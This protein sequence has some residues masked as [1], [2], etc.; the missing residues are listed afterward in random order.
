MKPYP[1]IISHQQLAEAIGVGNSDH[2][3]SGTIVV[4]IPIWDGRI[5]EGVCCEG[6]EAD[7]KTDLPYIEGK[8][9]EPFTKQLTRKGIK[10]VTK[11]GSGG[12][13][14]FLQWRLQS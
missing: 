1:R 4:Q 7:I 5:V 9:I 3:K 10:F 11:I 8:R 14:R 2:C 6:L 12:E 13:Q